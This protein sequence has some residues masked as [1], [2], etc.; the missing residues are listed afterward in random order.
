MGSVFFDRSGDR[1]D[2]DLILQSSR[3]DQPSEHHYSARVDRRCYRH[4]RPT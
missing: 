2:L 4:I 3:I 1:I